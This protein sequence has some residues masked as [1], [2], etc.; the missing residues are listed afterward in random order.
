LAA[1]LA[2]GFAA[3]FL[4]AV[5]IFILLLCDEKIRYKV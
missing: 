3:G 4:A 5:A 1:A 2:A